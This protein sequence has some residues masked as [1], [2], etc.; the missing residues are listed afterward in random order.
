M[1]CL[2]VY[3]QLLNDKI[4]RLIEMGNKKKL[5]NECSKCKKEFEYVYKLSK[6]LITDANIH[7]L[8]TH[9]II[10]YELYEKVIK[11]E[12]PE[13]NINYNLFNTNEL[14]IIDGLYEEGSNQIYIDKKKNIYNS[15]ENKYS[16]H[17]GLLY[18]SQN[19][20]D[21]VI[22]QLNSR[23]DKDD[24]TIYMPQN[25]EEAFEVDYLFHTHPKTPYLGSRMANSII[26]EFPSMADINHFIEH[27]NRGKLLG[28]LVIAPEGIYNI[29]K[30]IFNR[31]KI[32][33]DFDIFLSELEDTFIE[34]YQ[35]SMSDYSKIKDIE[36]I[37]GF[38]KIPEK[39]F[40]KNI[41]T[42]LE[43]IK[44][45]NYVLEKYDLTIDFYPRVKLNNKWIFPSIYIPSI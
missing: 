38:Y 43:F 7:E 32:R 8:L 36:K 19:K 1:N 41:S 27:H 22:V 39:I 45:I 44:R 30:Y 9:N 23:I 21:K 37:N 20:L 11:Y 16:E 34:C 28:S 17:Y 12:I 33:L 42:N 3:N 13:Y 15:K 5:S 31:D 29:R 10:E 35:D 18:F 40:Y 25:S 6:L 2:Y 4:M 14:N 24:P 26:Y